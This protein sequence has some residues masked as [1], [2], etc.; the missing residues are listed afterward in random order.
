MQSNIKNRILFEDN[1]L[2][3]IDKLPGEIVQGDKTGDVCLLDLLKQF[4]KDRDNKKGNVFL[5]LCHRIDRPTSGIVIFAKTSKCLSRLSLMFRENNIHKT[6]LALT[7]GIVKGTENGDIVH[8][9][10]YIY[11]NSKLNKSFVVDK[12]YE[13]AKKGILECKL[14]KRT[15]SYYL[16]EIALF[17]G[18]HHQIRVQLSSRGVHIKG[19]LKYGAKRSNADGSI[20]LHSYKVSFVHPVS[21]QTISVSSLPSWA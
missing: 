16:Y 10:D 13:G 18:R 11:R 9:E 5:G 17:T 1:H 3:I 14:L 2:I 21:K 8:L 20:C 12:T 19:D 15:I 6:Y 7:D 4:I